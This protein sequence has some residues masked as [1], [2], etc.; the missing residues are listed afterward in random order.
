MNIIVRSRDPQDHKKER[1]LR[2]SEYFVSSFQYGVYLC[3]FEIMYLRV[4]GR[5][6]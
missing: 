2:F 3:M 4:K 5:N 1:K 6:P